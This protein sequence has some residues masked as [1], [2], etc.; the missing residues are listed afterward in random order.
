MS[1]PIT[2]DPTFTEPYRVRVL[3]FAQLPERNKRYSNQDVLVQ[4]GDT[5]QL[6]FCQDEV[7]VCE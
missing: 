6:L 1:E 3:E 2:Y 7:E 4:F 5:T